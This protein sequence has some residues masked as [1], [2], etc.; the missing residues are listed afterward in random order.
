MLELYQAETCPSCT[1]VRERM[2]EAGLSYVIHNPREPR[3]LEKAIR[4]Q[5]VY[6]A[7]QAHAATDKIPVLV[8]HDRDES[9]TGRDDVLSHLETHYL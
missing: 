3:S 9:V 7:F 4:N 8:D 6:T 1:E 5:T 2:A